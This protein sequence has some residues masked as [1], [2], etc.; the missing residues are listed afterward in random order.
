MTDTPP[1]PRDIVLRLDDLIPHQLPTWGACGK[2][3]SS[4]DI[5]EARNTISQLRRD[6]LAARGAL[7]EQI[8]AIIED[9]L[10]VEVSDLPRAIIRDILALTNPS[11]TK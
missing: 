11:E 8:I 9:H 5:V 2:L 7:T 6:L 4:E 10:D 3:I 1:K